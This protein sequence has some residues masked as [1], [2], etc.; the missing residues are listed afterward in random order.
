MLIPDTDTDQGEITGGHRDKLDELPP[1]HSVTLSSHSD[2]HN[3]YQ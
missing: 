2:S 1:H 3:Q